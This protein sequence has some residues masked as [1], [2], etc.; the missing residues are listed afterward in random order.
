VRELNNEKV[1][2][3]RWSSDPKE[4]VLEALKPAKVKN[5]VFDPEKKSVQISVD[6]DQ[7]SLAIGKKGQNARLT[8]RLTGWEINIDK[9]TSA[10]TAV[11]QKVAQESQTL[12]GALPITEEQ[13]VTLVKSGFTNLE[14][15]HDA[16]VQ[17]LID[18]LGV[19]EAKAREIHEAV[20]GQGDEEKIGSAQSA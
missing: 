3:I 4:Y 10:T 12:A 16:D 2:I 19:E 15:L 8:S 11:E 7:L 17:D 5:L 6:E 18:I 1:D 14:G 13:A 9:D 20:H